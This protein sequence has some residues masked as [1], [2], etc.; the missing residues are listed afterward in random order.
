[1]AD[2]KWTAQRGTAVDGTTD[3]K[4]EKSSVDRTVDGENSGSSDTNRW[5]DDVVAPAGKMY[6]ASGYRGSEGGTTAPVTTGNIFSE[7]GRD[8]RTMGKRD[9]TLVLIMNQ[10]GL[11]ILALPTVARVLGIVPAIIAIIGIGLLSTYTAY[12]LLRFYPAPPARCQPRRHGLPRRQAPARDSQW[13]SAWFLVSSSPAAPCRWRCRWLSTP[14]L[15]TR[16]ARRA[17]SASRP[18]SASCCACRATCT[19]SRASASR[20]PS[21]SWRRSSPSSSASASSARPRTRFPSGRRRHHV[22]RRVSPNSAT[23]RTA[24]LNVAFAYAGKVGFVSYM[25]EMKDPVRGFIFAAWALAGRAS[26]PRSTSS[27]ASPIYGLAGE[28][29][30]SPSLGSAP[31]IPAKVAY[32]VVAALRLRFGLRLW[33][34]GHQVHVPSWP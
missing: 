16:Y 27:P 24:C 4:A 2:S 34:H 8:Y 28:Y 30:T 32:V 33:P 21:P 6:D 22:R 5:P 25:A 11:G 3:A 26:P 1:M 18:S 29:V 31:V 14:S 10:A 20:R 19:L 9:A 12:E 7:G 13:A 23:A 17:S 15:S